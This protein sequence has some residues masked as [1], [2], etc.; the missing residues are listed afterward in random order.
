[1]TFYCP[2]C[3]EACESLPEGVCEDCL[4]HNHQAWL[5]EDIRAQHWR[6]LTPAQR[7][8]AIKIACR[9]IEAS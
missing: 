8:A 5:L 2:Q 7:E 3:G 4:E 1:M 6:A 9:N